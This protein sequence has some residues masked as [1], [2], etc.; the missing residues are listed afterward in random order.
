MEEQKLRY[1]IPFRE[2][3]LGK[4]SFILETEPGCYE[5]TT[6]ISEYYILSH[7][8]DTVK[9]GGRI[10]LEFSDKKGRQVLSPIAIINDEKITWISWSKDESVDKPEL[11]DFSLL[12]PFRTDS[13]KPYPGGFIDSSRTSLPYAKLVK[14]EKILHTTEYARIFIIITGDFF[15]DSLMTCGFTI[16]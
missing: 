5:L 15:P 16:R 4:K 7:L 8:A 2:I 6:E 12:E 3:T 13:G 10:L 14:C 9:A 11:T 1:L